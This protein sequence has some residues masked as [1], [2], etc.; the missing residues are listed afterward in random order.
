VAGTRAT[1]QLTAG[2]RSVLVDVA[3]Y[4]FRGRRV[5]GTTVRVGAGAT[6]GW[7]PRGGAYVVVTPRGGG[8]VRGGVA[9][10]DGGLAAVPLTSLP[11][12]E[13]RPA[14]RPGLR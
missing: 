3:S 1:V 2:A 12:R 13:Q 5:D 9:Y 10:A 7:T 8:P 6:R 11:L 4:D 14:V